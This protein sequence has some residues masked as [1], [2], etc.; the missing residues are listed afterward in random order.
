MVS[1]DRLEEVLD[2][3]PQWH[4]RIVS[5]ALVTEDWG[6]GGFPKHRDISTI[7]DLLRLG[8]E[9][10]KIKFREVDPV[11]WDWLIEKIEEAR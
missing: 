3:D 6:D 2:R 11:I 1:V 4:H 8:A 5:E 7:N 10:L 9:G